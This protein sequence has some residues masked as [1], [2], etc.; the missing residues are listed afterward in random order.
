MSA[1]NQTDGYVCIC[2]VLTMNQTSLCTTFSNLT[3]TVNTS[4]VSFVNTA[5]VAKY[6]N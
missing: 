6:A 2:T 4:G 5:D 3:S 1:C